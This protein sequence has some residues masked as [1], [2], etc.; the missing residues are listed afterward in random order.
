MAI[1]TIPLSRLEAELTQSLNEC[2]DSGSTMVVE[3]PGQRFVSIQSIDPTD[4]DDLMNDLLATNPSF[5][6]LVAESKASPRKPF[7]LNAAPK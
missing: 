2:A 1:K 5:Q 6:K 7:D 3:L 4:Q